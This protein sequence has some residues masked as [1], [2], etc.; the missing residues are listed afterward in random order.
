MTF[1]LQQKQPEQKQP[2]RQETST[3]IADQGQEPM[4]SFPMLPIPD[5][6]PV[7]TIS[8]SSRPFQGV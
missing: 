4:M 8:K 1:P 2:D 6:P 5:M 7:P 3:P